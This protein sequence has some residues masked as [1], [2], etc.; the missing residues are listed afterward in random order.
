MPWPDDI[1]VAQVRIV[2]PTDRLVEVTAFY[3]DALGLPVLDSF[4]GHAGYDGVFIGLPGRDYH[5][6]FIRR[7]D[8]SPCPAPTRDNLLVLYIPDPAH[9]AG[10][11]ARLEG[12]GHKEVEPDNP[13]WRGRAVTYA[14]PDGWRVV[15]C[16]TPGV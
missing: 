10:L 5:L 12:L 13:Y 4:T 2:R 3:R 1:A 6:A 9:L 11:R 7:P 15:L 16:G 8:N 14:D